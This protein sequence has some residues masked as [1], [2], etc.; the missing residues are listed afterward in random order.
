MSEIIPFSGCVCTYVQENI[1]ETEEV[2]KE[3][4]VYIDGVDVDQHED[5]NCALFLFE[6]L[7][8]RAE[9][10]GIH[11]GIVTAVHLEQFT[12][13]KILPLELADEAIIKTLLEQLE[14]GHTQNETVSALYADPCC[15]L[16]A[17]GENEKQRPADVEVHPEEGVRCRLWKVSGQTLLAKAQAVLDKKSLILVQGRSVY[18]AMLRN[19]DRRRE[20]DADYSGKES[21]NYIVMALSNIDDSTSGYGMTIDPVLSTCCMPRLS[22]IPLLL[23]KLGEFFDISG[24]EVDPTAASVAAHIRQTLSDSVEAPDLVLYPGG[25]N[26]YTLHLRAHEHLQKTEFDEKQLG[27]DSPAVLFQRVILNHVLEVSTEDLQDSN[28]FSIPKSIEE[29]CAL[30]ESVANCV[31]FFAPEPSLSQVRDIAWD[32]I[33]VPVGLIR[34]RP[35]L[36]QDL[37]KFS[38]RD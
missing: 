13:G 1:S 3:L 25:R 2:D 37:V 9:G 14:V 21:Y 15:V 19:R 36:P 7:Y 20:T 38:L 35:M 11:R 28:I 31:A 24:G 6:I 4:R 12:S 10:P 8:D 33:Q 30:T 32:E 5:A 23:G 27:A 18:E 22:D 17:L 29:A 34:C 16:E 26:I